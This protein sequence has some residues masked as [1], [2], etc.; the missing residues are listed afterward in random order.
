[1]DIKKYF[2]P[3][4]PTFRFLLP[5]III[6][7]SALFFGIYTALTNSEATTEVLD[8]LGQFAE[9]F[10]D[11]SS[12]QLMLVIMV[13]N[14]LKSFVALI[15]GLLFG[16]PPFMYLL[17]NGNV[18]G[19]LSAH[20]VATGTPLAEVL[21]LLVPHGIIELTGFLLASS[22]GFLLGFRMYRRTR[23]K[24]SLRPHIRLALRAFVYII[25][26]LLVIASLVEAF[27]TPH[28]FPLVL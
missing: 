27:I 13:N 28:L 26:P 24:E 12:W 14:V 1:M 3:L 18:L 8:E 10:V 23:F 4:Q 20:L 16:I 7:L 11:L 25:A 6:F 5:T 21:I 2:Q 19:L 22:Y 17:I 15:G 9:L